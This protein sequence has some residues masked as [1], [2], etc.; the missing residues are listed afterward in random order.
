MN[1]YETGWILFSVAMVAVFLVIV[2]YYGFSV[3]I[4]TPHRAEVID[5][6]K[7]GEDSRFAS[8]RVEEVI[9][10]EEY[11]VYM[12]ARMWTF[13]PNEIVIPVGAKV[14]FYI[15]SPDAVHGF[16]VV[17]TN[18]QTMVMPGYISVVSAKFEKAGAYLIICN[19]YC[20]QGHHLMKAKLVVEGGV[21][22]A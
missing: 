9:P 14:T 8:P 17:G 5:P 20:G 7:I 3:G 15:T 19:E 22:S 6:K 4:Q 21:R 16:Q 13:L 10:G 18:V 11:R 12:V 2:G 1:R